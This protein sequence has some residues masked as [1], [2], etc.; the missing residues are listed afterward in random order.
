[1]GASALGHDAV[2][3]VLIEK[4]S[5]VNAKTPDGMTALLFA[6]QGG[7]DT[8]VQALLGRGAAIGATNDIG[9][10]ALMVAA[11]RGHAAVLQTLL[12]RGAAVNAKGHDGAT[13]LMLASQHGRAAAVRVLLAA[14]ADVNARDDTGQS[15]LS[16]AAWKGHWEV[17]QLLLDSR[18]DVNGRNDEGATPLSNAAEN[19]HEA[20][21]QALLA[22]GA[23]VHAKNTYGVTALML[24]S[25]KGH[26]GVVQLLL[27]NGA[28]PNARGTDGSTALMAASQGG[29]GAIVQLLL[30]A[31][32]D[33][34]AK[35]RDG[36]TA[37]T[38]AA[39]NGH[40]TVVQLLR[41]AAGSGGAKAKGAT[42]SY[43]QWEKCRDR[44]AA[45]AD[46]LNGR[47]GIED[48]IQRQCGE[49]PVREAGTA[50]GIGVRP[51]DLVRSTTWKKKF[52]DVTGDRYAAFVERLAVSGVTELQDGWIIGDGNAAHAGTIDEAALAIEARSERVFAA[53]MVGGSR[54]YGF[55]FGDS[56]TNAPPPL[57][58]WAKKS[59]LQEDVPSAKGTSGAAAVPEQPVQAG[60][61][62]P[63]QGTWDPAE[64]CKPESESDSRIVVERMRIKY[65]EA[66]CRL[67]KVI[68]ADA[69]D[70][71]GRFDCEGEGNRWTQQ[72]AL[73]IND[74]KL[75][76]KST[77]TTWPILFRCR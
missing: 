41:A 39:K 38:L 7:H 47:Q 8:A 24:A 45:S 17:V 69:R 40:D 42:L 6:A 49:P 30:K 66:D 64:R 70:F 26:R 44:A 74:G 19:G 61:P 36:T 60:V 33:V 67:T 20:M 2:V 9:R 50:R 37:T 52:M 77:R 54:I 43:A 51:A 18:A 14:G 11:E 3:Q 4:G 13:A 16:V 28:D 5:D 23:D 29:H 56:W 71:S 75:I 76:H 15:A 48:A 27:G 21:V 55:G 63:F 53:I 46:P 35:T 73:S 72:I 31:G 25:W 59:G 32:A 58:R 22:K 10:T 62:K 68:A 34:G 1:M 12:A 65:W 57:Q